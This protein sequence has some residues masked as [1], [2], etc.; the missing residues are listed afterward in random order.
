MTIKARLKI[1]YKPWQLY[2]FKKNRDVK[3]SAINIPVF[4]LA[5]TAIAEAGLFN[6][7]AR[8]IIIMISGRVKPSSDE[9]E[10]IKS[11]SLLGFKPE[12]IIIM[13]VT[14]GIAIPVA[15]S[16]A[17]FIFNIFLIF[18]ICCFIYLLLCIL[19]IQDI[20]R[21]TRFAN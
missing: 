5:K 9:K 13:K 2:S 3:I 4:V 12:R 15:Q 17:R 6:I 20:L 21:F 10:T 7:A 1:S 8:S 11:I 19:V 16:N 18:F 14:A